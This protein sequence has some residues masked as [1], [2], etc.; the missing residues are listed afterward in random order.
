MTSTT[1]KVLLTVLLLN[2]TRSQVPSRPEPVV[3]YPMPSRYDQPP[4]GFYGL[5]AIPSNEAPPYRFGPEEQA[6][7]YAPNFHGFY[8]SGASQIAGGQSSGPLGGLDGYGGGFQGPVGGINGM[9]VGF[10]EGQGQG[11]PL[12]GLYSTL[13]GQAGYGQA[14]YGGGGFF[15]SGFLTGAR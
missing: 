9:V 8:G 1:E 4:M 13:L 6:G 11:G 15:P 3:E 5:P 10:N 2:K 12:G 14:G 7:A